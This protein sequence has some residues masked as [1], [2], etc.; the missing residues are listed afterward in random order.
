MNPQ[1]QTIDPKAR[2][3]VASLQ[4]QRSIEAAQEAAGKT[5]PSAEELDAE[6]ARRRS[7]AIATEQSEERK[8]KVMNPLH[9][10]RPQPAHE[11]PDAQESNPDIEVRLP[12]VVDVDG[13]LALAARGLPRQTSRTRSTTGSEDG[14]R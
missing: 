8:G 12:H 3:I 13:P 9:V 5:A 10:L 14:F 1:P 4:R 11:I 2:G 6:I 7:L